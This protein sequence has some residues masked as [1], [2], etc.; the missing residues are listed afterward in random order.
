MDD[1]CYAGD[2]VKERK[3]EFL[4]GKFSIENDSLSCIWPPKN[5]E[6]FLNHGKLKF[7]TSQDFYIH[8]G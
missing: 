8:E 6:S 3:R 1:K 7:D 4:E 2:D 5:F